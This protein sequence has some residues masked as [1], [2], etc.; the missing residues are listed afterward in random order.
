MY[1]NVQWTER[2]LAEDINELI[3]RIDGMGHPSD[4]PSKHALSFLKEMVRSKR[5]Q[6]ARLRRSINLA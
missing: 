6:L 2:S 5:Q 3:G 1:L 4:R